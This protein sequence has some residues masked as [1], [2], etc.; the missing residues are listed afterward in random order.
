MKHSFLFLFLLFAGNSFATPGIHEALKN[1]SG[2]TVLEFNGEKEEALLFL[3][4]ASRFTSLTHIRIYGITDSISAEQDILAIA[5]CP[6]VT[7]VSF[8]KCGFAHLSPAVKML[9]SVKDVEI[10]NCGKLEIDGTFSCLSGMPSL[11]TISYSTEKLVRLPRTFKL[12]RGLQ[13]ISISNTDLSLADGYALNNSNA[14]DL[15]VKENLQLGFGTSVLLLEYSCYDKPSAKEH[16]SIM[17]DML[18][19]AVGFHDDVEMPRRN[20]AFTRNNPLVKPPIIGL[21][22][23]K[24][25][26]TTN[27][28]TGGLVEYPSGTKI[29]IPSHAFVD[30]AGNEIKGD[31]TI[32]YREFRD[33]VDILVSGIPMVYDSAGISGDFESAGM[34]EINAS[35]NGKEVFL[36][37]GKKVDVEFAVVDTASTF[38][39]YRLDPAKGWVYE[40]KPGSVEQKQETVLTKTPFVLSA[41]VQRYRFKTMAMLKKRPS[42]GDTLSFEAR[43]EDTNYVYMKRVVRSNLKSTSRAWQL[44]SSASWQLRKVPA[45]KGNTCFMLNRILYNHKK[46]SLY[47][48]NNPELQAFAGV[49]WQATDPI[50][51]KEFRAYFSRRAGITDVRV[52]YDGGADFTLELKYLWGFKRISVTPVKIVNKK[53]VAYSE[54]S[55]ARRFKNYTK[56]LN[57]RKIKLHREN[58]RSLRN[59]LSWKRAAGRDSV[60]HWN[61]L[62]GVMNAEEQPMDYNNWVSY[63]RDQSF[64]LDS[65]NGVAGASQTTAVYQALSIQGFGIF[66]CDQIRRILKPVEVFAMAMTPDGKARPSSTIFVIDKDKNMVFSYSNYTGS[67]KIIYGE[68]AQNKL[69]SV[70]PDGSLAYTDETEFTR[71][72]KVTPGTFGFPSREIATKP[73]SAEELRKIMF[74]SE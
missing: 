62:R 61:D 54:K 15:F 19:G 51:R 3:R 25:V 33:P 12:M 55:C 23:W 1:P 48:A 36:A 32:D 10:S 34:F 29:L 57:R 5:A 30:A 38:N 2:I 21:D 11:K 9:V 14:Q 59:L 74:P 31:V 68:N 24:S 50:S 17:R 49:L 64:K 72:Q 69:L 27:A 66:N 39:F 37:P 6:L 44:K 70:A 63:T 7:K 13:R 42:L 73:V 56:G 43:Y 58:A 46:K 53:P 18:Q 22:V 45:G 16:I 65:T 20:V 67:T 35:V 52:E 28:T 41:A 47:N 60:T 8:D 4:N 40:D 71:M 26:Y